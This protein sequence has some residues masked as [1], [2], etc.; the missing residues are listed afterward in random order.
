[1][2]LHFPQ[3]RSAFVF[4][5][6]G[7]PILT[8]PRTKVIIYADEGCTT[9]ANIQD[10]AG[11][12]ITDSAIYTAE[13]LL[14]EFLGPESVTQVW[15]KVVGMPGHALDPQTVS[16]LGFFNTTRG[17]THN[18]TTPATNWIVTHNLGRYP[19][20]VMMFDPAMTIQYDEFA[21]HHT[22]TNNL[23]ISHDISV[24]GI[25]LVE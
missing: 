21:V 22:D 20:A 24:S 12:A 14:P 7:K 3:D 10:L 25:A 16:L 19:A 9:I 23:M 11:V 17:Y 13:G 1:V 2:R 5:G 8:P 6:E 15:A 4:Q 18:Q